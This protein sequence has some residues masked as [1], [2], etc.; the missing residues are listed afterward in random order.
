MRSSGGNMNLTVKYKDQEIKLNEKLLDRQDCWDNL[1]ELKATHLSRLIVE[2]AMGLTDDAQDIKNLN[3]TW[4]ELQFKLQELWGFPKN[5]D[6]HR[7]WDIPACTCPKMD[8]GVEHELHSPGCS[9]SSVSVRAPH[10][11]QTK[12]FLGCLRFWAKRYPGK[13][14]MS[15]PHMR[16]GIVFTHRKYF[17]CAS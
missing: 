13:R 5:Q 9:R 17:T 10:W 14:S 11:E 3:K 16:H 7:F 4:T 8:N 15:S 6:Y 12:T 1:D 2:H